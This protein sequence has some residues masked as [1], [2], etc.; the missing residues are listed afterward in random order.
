MSGR[1]P[2][3]IRNRATDGRMRIDLDAFIAFK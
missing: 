3:E 2:T 1:M